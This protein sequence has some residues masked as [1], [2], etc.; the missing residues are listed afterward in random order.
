MD[1]YETLLLRKLLSYVKLMGCF[2]CRRAYLIY[3]RVYLKN[4]FSGPFDMNKYCGGEIILLV[5]VSREKLL[6]ACPKKQVR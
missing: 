6:I 3:M 5:D 4:I 1:F 2:F